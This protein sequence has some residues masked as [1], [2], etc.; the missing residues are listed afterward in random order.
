M[1]LHE[2]TL[3]NFR[4][5]SELVF[6]P[7]PKAITVLLS[8]NGTG[9]T[10]VLEAIYALTTASS[11]RTSAASDMIRSNEHLAEVHGVLFQHERRVQIDLTLTRGTRNTTKR[12]LVNGQRPHSRASVSEVLPLTVFTP[13]GVDIVRQGPEQRRNYLTTLLTDVDLSTG[14]V[15]ERFT[16]VLGQRNAV[17]RS[18]QGESPTTAQRDELNVWDT[19]FCEASERL[20]E[21]RLQLLEQLG[22]LITRYY[23]A[24]AHNDR[25]VSAHYERSW[26]GELDVALRNVL[27]D[28]QFRGHS[29]IGPQRDDVA[30]L[31]DGRDARRQAS[32]GEQRSLALALR[33]AGHELVR[34]QRGL[35]PLLLLDDV[36]SELDPSR[37]DRL[38]QL[39]PVGQTLVTTAS[40]LPNGMNPA[41]IVDLSSVAS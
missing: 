18:L 35:D 2:L 21:V 3:R 17:L 8:P 19:E 12:M 39:L 22:P 11:F 40:P 15:I 31:L 33:L 13:E 16:R 29:T 34:Q 9:K 38:L 23:Q 28:D 20:I 6:E 25:A 4:S 36:F 26:V 37:S 27:R 30:L 41:A 10:S 32:Q 1:G 14:D 24:I 5:F 7:D